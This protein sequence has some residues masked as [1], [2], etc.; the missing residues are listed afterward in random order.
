M[1]R[2]FNSADFLFPDKFGQTNFLKLKFGKQ[3]Y[4]KN[5]KVEIEDEFDWLNCYEIVVVLNNSQSL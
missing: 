3:A 5:C 1:V 2:S 4:F